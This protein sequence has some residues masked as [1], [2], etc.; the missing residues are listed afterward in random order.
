[1]NNRSADIKR[2]VIFLLLSFA[3]AWIPWIIM[4]SLYDFYDWFTGEK[5]YPFLWLLLLAGGSPAIASFLT[6]C[7]TK[8]GIADDSLRLKLKGNLKYYVLALLLPLSIGL[9]RGTIAQ[10]MHIAEDA[11]LSGWMTASV[12]VQAFWLS[13]VMA[14][15]TFG[16]EYGWR[17]YLYP[18]LEK[19]TNRPA[20]LIIG[21]IIWGLWHAPLTVKGHNFGT[22]YRGFPWLG[23]LLM[24]GFCVVLGIFLHWLTQKSGSVYPASIAHSATNNG[25]T[26]IMMAFVQVNA[27]RR[28]IPLR[29][30]LILLAPMLLY[31]LFIPFLMNRRKEQ[32]CV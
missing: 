13:P 28:D 19:V 32:K 15:N 5:Q 6:R 3:I 9:L 17:G 25:A 16:E 2:I 7:I 26:L 20:A 30:S 29:A 18:K 27:D 14:F 8:E 24:C 10:K 21:G 12:I 31:L 1:M 4:N 11:E 22:G 23:I